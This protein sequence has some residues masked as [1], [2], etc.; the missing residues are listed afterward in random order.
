MNTN[1]TI[2]EALNAQ[3][4]LKKS[5]VVTF[6]ETVKKQ[7]TEEVNAGV[8]TWMQTYVDNSIKSVNVNDSEIRVYATESKNDGIAIY[9]RSNWFSNKA[10]RKHSCELSWYSS[11]ASSADTEKLKYLSVL[12][13]L[14]NCLLAVEDQYLNTWS[15]L[16]KAVDDQCSQM[17]SEIYKIERSISEVTE[18]IKKDTAYKYKQIGFEITSFAKSSSCS[19]NNDG[20]RSIKENDAIINLQYGRRKWDKLYIKS[21]KVLSSTKGKYSLLVTQM[22]SDKETTV[23]VTASRMDQFV[24][25]ILDWET[26]GSKQEAENAKSIYDR[27]LKTLV[28]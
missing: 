20:T 4:K 21:Y 5:D 22:H 7:N 10:D 25:D 3:L 24:N 23:E 14:A 16:L 6:E 12:G 13:N 15:K 9:K 27:Y 26:R 8:L 18:N 2:L 28:A 11:S 17:Y 19:W 1:H